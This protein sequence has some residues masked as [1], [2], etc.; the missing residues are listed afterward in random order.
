MNAATTSAPTC[1]SCS[2]PLENPQRCRACGTIQP[3]DPLR[4][5]FATLGLPR[6]FDLE[7]VEIERRLVDFGRDLHPDRAAADGCQRTL[8]VLGAAQ[9]NEAYGV[10]KDPYRRGEYLLK[11]EGGRAASED[12]SVPEGFLEIM[13]EEREEV[14]Q[15]LAQGGERLARART[16]L[17]EKLAELERELSA[18]FGQIAA[19]AD[20]GAVLARLRRTLN[21]MAYYRGQ[22]RDLR[23]AARHPEGA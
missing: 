17:E 9:V 10:L 18:G 5:H 15:A 22:L 13:L 7:E 2:R 1:R 19:A 21:V 23:E 20:R 11:L 16:P 14:E 12:K 4:D 8:A 3:H 6:R